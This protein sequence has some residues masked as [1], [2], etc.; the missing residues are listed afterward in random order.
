[1]DDAWKLTIG[2][3]AHL[4]VLAFLKADCRQE[5]YD[6][7]LLSL[8]KGLTRDINFNGSC[9]TDSGDDEGLET[10][11][12]Q[13]THISVFLN[14]IQ[15]SVQLHRPVDHAEAAALQEVAAEL[16][17]IAAQLEYNVV[18]RATQNLRE[19]I[20]SSPFED[21]KK[22]LSQEVA[23]VMRHGV[24]LEHLPQERIMLALS[25]TL[26]KGVCQQVPHLLRSLFDVALQYISPARAR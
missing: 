20:L 10:D 1:M 15:P 25:L 8:S 9:W 6:E 11:G 22:H 21:W 24:G 23:K 18:V 26:V 2:Q 16:R 14:D 19:N 13:P 7:E 4:V 17:E 3:N 5:D 12:H